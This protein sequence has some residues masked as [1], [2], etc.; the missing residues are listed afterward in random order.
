LQNCQIIR[1]SYTITTIL[2]EYFHPTKARNARRA[3]MHSLPFVLENISSQSFWIV[4]DICKTIEFR[5]RLNLP[6]E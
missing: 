3:N 5:K 1:I 6:P 4:Y 2:L